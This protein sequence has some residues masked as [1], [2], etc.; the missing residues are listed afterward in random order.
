[1]SC[2]CS[3]DLD[4]KIKMYPTHAAGKPVAMIP[5]CAATRHAHFV[6]EIG[7]ASCRERVKISVVAVLPSLYVMRVLFRSR[8]QDQDVSDPRRRQTGGH[9]SQLCGHP[10]RAFCD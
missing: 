5:N 7:R 8:H 10:P 1:M 6:M 2:V 9:D 4:I 3:S